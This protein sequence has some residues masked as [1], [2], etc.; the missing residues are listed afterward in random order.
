MQP[1]RPYTPKGATF[2]LDF[3][4]PEEV[5]DPNLV[6]HRG[7]QI[8]EPGEKERECRAFRGFGG[9]RRS[10]Q[11][12][13]L[14][15]RPTL[16]DYAGEGEKVLV[17][18]TYAGSLLQA[19]V[20]LRCDILASCEDAAYGMGIQ[21]DNFP[22]LRGRFAGTTKAWPTRSLED[23]VVI[24]HPPCAAFS[25]QNSGGAGQ[26]AE[27]R[28]TDAKKFAVTKGV[29]DYALGKRCRVLLVESVV[30]TMEGA[31]AIHDAVAEAH[32]YHLYRILQN[33]MT[34]GV[35]Q[36][37]P[38]FWAAFVR[39]DVAPD[40]VWVHHV[41]QF[42][43]VK[44]ILLD[45]PGPMLPGLMRQFEKLPGMFRQAGLTDSQ[46]QDALAGRVRYGHA[47]KVA[48][49]ALGLPQ[50]E[51]KK[52]VPIFG[53]FE[54]AQFKI[55]DPGRPAHTLLTD[56]R[57]IYNGRPLSIAE[58]KAIMGY[59]SGYRIPVT[60]LRGMLSRGVV[61]AV[62]K[63][64]LRHALDWSAGVPAPEGSI[65]VQPGQVAD[66]RPPKN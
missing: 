26:K 64:V 9:H 33:A 63:W 47:W 25:T 57:W 49:H 11:D 55:L 41:P 28:G 24:S 52:L 2:A 48:G 10:K 34:F 53:R 46:I 16:T 37:R 14:A 3:D 61:P 51:A 45:D 58:H 56:S 1:R 65:R 32:G 5:A 6:V 7:K 8:L 43:A 60:D 19:A 22:Q 40:G 17:I 44:D 66:V 20:D 15:L 18:N 31:R 30:P 39:P 27:N 38:R 42:A 23:T 13:L 59:P 29:L 35:P 36:N 62:A 21:V 50:K 4:A 12:D 54:S